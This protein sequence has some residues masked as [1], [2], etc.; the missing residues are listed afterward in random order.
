M[1]SVVLLQYY[2]Y[3]M[4]FSDFNP[5]APENI[6][7]IGEAWDSLTERIMPNVQPRH[8]AE[9]SHSGTIVTERVNT[10][11]NKEAKS[12][13][14]ETPPTSEEPTSVEGVT[15][16]TIMEL[17]SHNETAPCV[18]KIIPTPNEKFPPVT[19]CTRRE[20]AP[21]H[22]DTPMQEV[23][24]V[25]EDTPTIIEAIPINCEI[26]DNAITSANGMPMDSDIAIVNVKT[27]LVDHE[28]EE[29]SRNSPE[30]KQKNKSKIF[31]RKKA[32][33]GLAAALKKKKE[34]PKLYSLNPIG[35]PIK[36]LNPRKK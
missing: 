27:E 22:E 16:P 8:E 1:P 29:G 33:P 14:D 23:A 5:V 10:S 17:P 6:K 28:H 24:P 4:F 13:R 3:L 30:E 20:Y 7:T 2:C 11:P 26:R 31:E 21:M 19:D 35:I 36:Y 9:C 25:Q 15:T 32:I 12:T 34:R 18:D